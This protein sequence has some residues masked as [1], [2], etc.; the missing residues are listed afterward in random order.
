MAARTIVHAALRFGLSYEF[1]FLFDTETPRIVTSGDW[2]AVTILPPSV[3]QPTSLSATGEIGRIVLAT[4]K[5]ANKNFGHWNLYVSNNNNFANAGDPIE[6]KG[7]T[8]TM[9]NLGYLQRLAFGRRQFKRAEFQRG[10]LRA[11][12]ALDT[13][14]SGRAGGRA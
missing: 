10:E 7:R 14:P 9:N 2:Q 13:T 6:Q 3:P 5:S 11:R 1:A 4:T 8:F 12:R